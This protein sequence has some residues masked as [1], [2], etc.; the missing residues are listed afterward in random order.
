MSFKHSPDYSCLGSSKFVD[1]ETRIANHGHVFTGTR[2]NRN[3]LK[4]FTYII[5]NI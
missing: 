4:D 2:L 1:Y 3:H 5:S